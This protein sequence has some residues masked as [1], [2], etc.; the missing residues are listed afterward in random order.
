MKFWIDAQLPPSLANWLKENFQVEAWALRDLGLR[1]AEDMDIFNSAKNQTIVIITKDSDFIELVTRFGTPPQILWVTC[2]NV[3]NR[4]LKEIFQQTFS[5]ATNLLE[6]GEA[7][8]E[9]GDS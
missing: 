1:D 8:V 7:V 2:G 5:K 6:E 4:N 3:T 9:I